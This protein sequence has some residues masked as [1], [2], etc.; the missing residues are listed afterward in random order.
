MDP[1]VAGQVLTMMETVVETEA[2]TGTRASVPHYRV[3]GKTGTSR[4]AA[5]GGYS[6]RQYVA[7]FAGVAPVT[8]PR[9][10]VV[11]LLDDPSG[12]QYYG[13]QVAAPLGGDVL[14]AALRLFDVPPDDAAGDILRAGEEPPEAAG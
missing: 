1:N 5:A 7:V 14:K 8:N 6:D 2:G 10:C 12:R 11:V 3:A 9:L 4:K 13:G